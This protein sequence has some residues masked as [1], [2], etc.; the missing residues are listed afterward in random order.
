ML[1]GIDISITDLLITYHEYSMSELFMPFN[2]S[3][4]VIATTRYEQGRHEAKR[5][6]EL[7]QN[8]RHIASSPYNFIAA[9][10]RYDQEYIKYFTGISDVIL[11]PS[12]C[13]Y[14]TARYN[15]VKK[16]ILLAPA[17]GVNGEI[18]AS[19]QVHVKQYNADLC[20]GCNHIDIIP[21]RELY[22]YFKYEDIANHPA[23]VI[24]PYQISFMSFFEFY[25]MEIPMFVPCPELLAEWHL[26]I[27]AISER[28]WANVLGWP[29]GQSAV[30]RHP[31]STSILLSDPNNEYGR[32]A[33]LEWIKLADFYTVEHIIT[34]KSWDHLTTLL[35][36]TDLRS[37]SKRMREYSNTVLKD[38]EKNWDIVL[39]NVRRGVKSKRFGDGNRF[40]ETSNNVTNIDNYCK[41][42][43]SIND[44]LSSATGLTLKNRCTGNMKKRNFDSREKN[45]H[46]R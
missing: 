34:F 16:E 8:L 9:N 14:V 36:T 11:L 20:S 1:P 24:I 4:I 5:W 42:P 23:I 26:T 33:V 19:M 31:N 10:N 18:A 25:R 46:E 6:L 32:E 27:G 17:R 44:A 3:I 45:R 30:S 13:G 43:P 41:M 12:Y 22:P 21:I 2:T 28:T 7:N 15:P 37:V 29:V 40:Y 35:Q 39:G 38:L